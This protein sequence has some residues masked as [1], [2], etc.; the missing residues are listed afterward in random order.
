[1]TKQRSARASAIPL[2]DNSRQ[3]SH[4][5]HIESPHVVPPHRRAMPEG[6]DNLDLRIFIAPSPGTV[7]G[8]GER[9]GV[10]ALPRA[11][12]PLFDPD[13]PASEDVIMRNEKLTRNP[14]ANDQDRAGTV[15]RVPKLGTTK[16]LFCITLL[17]SCISLLTACH[18]GANV[19]VQDAYAHFHD[20][21]GS[22]FQRLNAQ[23]NPNPSCSCREFAIWYVT[24][25]E[26]SCWGGKGKMP[27]FN[28]K[29]MSRLVWGM[30]IVRVADTFASVRSQ[31][32]QVNRQQCRSYNPAP[33]TE[34]PNDWRA[35]VC[36]SDELSD[37]P[38]IMVNHK[39]FVAAM[40]Q[41]VGI[42]SSQGCSQAGDGGAHGRSTTC[43]GKGDGG[44]GQNAQ[45][46]ARDAHFLIYVPGF[47]T[48]FDAAHDR[49]S[50]IIR[51]TDFEGVPILFSWPTYGGL[52]GYLRD[53]ESARWSSHKLAE[54]VRTLKCLKRETTHD[55]QIR[56]S[57]IA[58]STGASAIFEALM[59]LRNRPRENPWI[60]QL[61][62]SAAD[63][64]RDLFFDRY[65]RV[66]AGSGGDGV[67]HVR[68]TTMYFSRHD[69]AL[70]SSTVIRRSTRI[71]VQYRL[72]EG[73]PK[74]AWQ[75]EVEN[76][77]AVGR[78]DFVDVS[79]LSAGLSGHDYRLHSHEV[80]WD[81]TLTLRGL[82][83][84]KR[85]LLE[86]N[87]RPYGL[88]YWAIAPVPATATSTAPCNCAR[89][90]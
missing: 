8:A 85:Q 68:R 27:Q 78:I 31:M 20:D 18:T 89:N 38:Q 22:G 83:P 70:Y 59:L 48:S 61:I 7:P 29:R 14:S 44:V 2:G 75:R 52:P 58:H 76:R 82:D 41:S 40:K 63:V 32:P 45:N 3:G 15:Y 34:E 74:V 11:V 47:R 86:R 56:V 9:A 17:I 6:V 35:N 16:L 67:A 69:R 51:S 50:R 87:T 77:D 5:S 10:R 53:H 49:F 25:R 54:L 28:R 57:V 39:C 64:D 72:L 1:M 73:Y 88:P 21:I 13:T 12:G 60:D 4:S 84:R 65:R 90:H 80:M 81:I 66:L 24:D 23:G 33:C 55:S 79:D 43:S 30:T 42:D 62:V 26:P 36:P 37:L 19:Y 46:A 71:G